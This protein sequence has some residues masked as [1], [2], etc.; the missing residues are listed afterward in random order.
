[1]SEQAHYLPISLLKELSNF[2]ILEFN[3][4]NIKNTTNRSEKKTLS[5]NYAIESNDM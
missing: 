4:K 2:E 5:W 1:M 3:I